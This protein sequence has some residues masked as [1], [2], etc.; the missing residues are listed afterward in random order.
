MT[1]NDTLVRRTLLLDAVVSGANGAVYLVAAGPLESALGLPAE[2]LRPL[3]AFLL[4]YAA[5]LWLV[6]T[7]AELRLGAV[8]VV[9]AG[10]VAWTVASLVVLAGGWLTPTALGEAWLAIQALAVAGI[11]ALQAYALRSSATS[12]DAVSASA[13]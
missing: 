9:V 10:N 11:A 8:R 1:T 3:G 2:L 6:A 7:R 12:V 4:A 5:L 13:G